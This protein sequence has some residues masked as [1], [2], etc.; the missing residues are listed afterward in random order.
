M[1]A[2][3]QS[4]QPEEAQTLIEAMGI[5]DQLQSA[6]PEADIVIPAATYLQHIAPTPAHEAFQQ[7]LR[8]GPGAMTLRESEAQGQSRAASERG[9]GQGH[10]QGAELSEI[11][12]PAERVRQHFYEQAVAV[13]VPEEQAKA[14]AAVQAAYYT[15]RAARNTKFK[16]AW[17]AYQ[18]A[19]ISMKGQGTTT[20][21]PRGPAGEQ[22]D[23]F[24]LFAQQGLTPD[25]KGMVTLSHWSE[26]GRIKQLD[27]TMWGENWE[28]L[29]DD[30]KARVG[31]A[32]GRVYW[33]FG[34]GQ[35]GQ[36]QAG[37][38][39]R[40]APLRGQGPVRAAVPHGPGPGGVTPGRARGS[41]RRGR[42]HH[43]RRAAA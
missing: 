29:P 16:D 2:Y 28:V 8:L 22:G 35:K 40:A 36:Y 3:L 12:N 17:D 42:E 32:P 14:N 9:G 13:G 37:V 5:G 30:E 10:G 38:W 26:K 33:G 23:V 34:T 24:S 1:V 4:V 20:Q 7:D 6:A 11:E 31:E 25:E 41:G 27:P 21:G 43:R 39:H 19:N 18:D 15:Q